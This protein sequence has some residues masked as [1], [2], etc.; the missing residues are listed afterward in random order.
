ME[1]PVRKLKPLSDFIL[2]IENKN[3][4]ADILAFSGIW[5][6]I[7]DSVFQNLTEDLIQNRKQNNIT[8]K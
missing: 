5:N 7:D 1:I 3:K 4:K 6:D 2:K 8:H